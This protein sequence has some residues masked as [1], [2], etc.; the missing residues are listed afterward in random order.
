MAPYQCN[1]RRQ[2][3][4][5]FSYLRWP[6]IRCSPA[7]PYPAEDAEEPGELEHVLVTARLQPIS[8][9]EVGS[10]VT[11]ITREEIEQ[12]QVKYLS[13]LLRDVP[14]FSVSQSGGAGSQTQV[15]V[16]GAEAN[17]LLVLM[18][19]VRAN[20]P[21]ASGEF[22]YQ[23]ALTSNIERIEII[24]GPQSATWGSDAIAGV[25]NIIRKKDVEEQYLS[26]NVEAGSFD[27]FNASV[28]G[29]YSGKVFQISGGLSYLDTDGTNVSRSGNEKD[30]AENTTGNIALEFDAGDAFSLRFSGQLIDA[31]NEYDDIRLLCHG[32]ARGRRPGNGNQ[33]GFPDRRATLR[34]RKPT[35]GQAVF[36]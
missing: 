1:N 6:A 2:Y 13:E 26:G 5:H 7:S 27:T 30:G 23:F 9:G 25:I 36:L 22:Q 16:R 18:D 28:D 19:G 20:D 24:R 32:S 10:S 3:G 35:R 17:Q 31:R 15:R 4:S 8:I 12:K 21:A 29:G 14:G 34:P 11:V 33:S